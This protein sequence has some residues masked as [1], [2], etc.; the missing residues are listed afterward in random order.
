MNGTRSS[1]TMVF[2]DLKAQNHTAPGFVMPIASDC[3]LPHYLSESI[4]DEPKRLNRE[5]RASVSYRL[6]LQTCLDGLNEL[7][8]AHSRGESVRDVI[9]RSV[10]NLFAN[11]QSWRFIAPLLDA[12]IEDLPLDINA[13]AGVEDAWDW[14]DT[15]FQDGLKTG[16]IYDFAV[17][18]ANSAALCSLL[19]STGWGERGAPVDTLLVAEG[20][21]AC[22][23]AR[24]AMIVSLELARQLSLTG[25]P[26]AARALVSG[27][28]A[29]SIASERLMTALCAQG[30]EAA[31]AILH[32]ESNLIARR[33]SGTISNSVFRALGAAK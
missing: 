12:A 10:D 21:V 3:S 25:R 15:A 29:P 20:L 19:A 23:N 9:T 31:I 28:S 32:Q 5:M 26:K 14:V 4:F 30:V 13:H 7:Y 22:T 27:L 18:C 16:Q 1:T 8:W 6:Y 17:Y 24:I 2:F 11:G 33:E